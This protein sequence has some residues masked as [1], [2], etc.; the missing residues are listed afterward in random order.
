MKDTN[1]QKF[2]KISDLLKTMSRP[3]LYLLFLLR[4]LTLIRAVDPTVWA[5]LYV[6]LIKCIYGK[7]FR[8]KV[9]MKI[10]IQSYSIISIDWMFH[11][12]WI[13]DIFN[14]D[15]ETELLNKFHLKRKLLILTVSWARSGMWSWSRSTNVSSSSSSSHL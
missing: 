2:R 12:S 10:T 7:K 14:H 13:K 15:H 9:Q 6:W 1:F 4:N 3:K 8:K 5:I 11:Y